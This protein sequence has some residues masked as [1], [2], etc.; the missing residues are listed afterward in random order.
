MARLEDKI[1]EIKDPELRR[2]IAEEVKE[3]KEKKQF[4]LVY[5][6]HQPEVVPVFR[7]PVQVGSTVAKKMGNLGET[8][9]VVRIH[10]GQVELIK[11]A[12][13]SREITS[14]ETLT[15]VRRMGE[16]IYPALTLIDAVENGDH[17]K[18]HHILIEAENY[19]ALQLLVYLY[20]GKVDCIYIDPP[21]NTGARDWKYNN[22]YVDRNDQWRHSKWLA[23]IGK[24]LQ[25]AKKL[26]K[27]DTGVLIITIDEHEVH[28][29][30]MLLESLFPDAYRQMVTIVV[31]PKGVT[32]GR[33][34]R[35]EEYAIFCFMKDAY[36][37]GVSDDLLTFIKN[38]GTKSKSPRWKG[39]LRSGTSARRQDRKGM[40]YPVLVDPVRGAVVGVGNPLPL[41]EEPDLEATIEGYAV[42]WPIRR[43]GSYG[44]WSVGPDTL[45]DLIAKGYVALG[46]YDEKRKTFGITYLSQEL[47]RQIQSGA[48][49][50]TGFDET[51]NCV[52][53]E[54]SEARTRAIK[55]VWHRTIH[56]AG[57][58]GSDLL[59]AI[60]GKS[61]LF[62]FPKSLYAVR[63]AIS[64]IVR[65]RPTAL[66]VDF[67][68]GSGTTLNAVNLLNLADGG[69][70]QCI[71][72]TNN[73]VSEDD[74]KRLSKQGFQ[75]GDPEWEAL[76]ICR[77][78]T[79][80]RSKYTIL[81]R[82]DD[83]T[84]LQGE[85]LTSRTVIHNKPRNIRQLSIVEGRLLTR[86]QRKELATLI[87]TV[88]QSKIT[89]APWFLDD[90]ISTSILFDVTQA[91]AWLEALMEAEHVSDFYV[92]TQE[93]RLFNTIKTGIQEL[94]GP[95]E[96]E[97]EEKH[98]LAK[99]FPVN[100]EY[101]KL[102]FLEP[103]EVAARW[104][105]ASILPILWMMSGA[106]GRCPKVHAQ[107]TPWL[108]PEDCPFVVLLHETRFREFRTK[109]EGR[110]DI[111]HVFLVTNSDSAFHDMQSELPAGII[112]VQ[113]YKNYLENFKI[114][115]QRV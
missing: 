108:I 33:F 10:D 63:D 67:F 52:T 57:A 39:L 71:L 8:Y 76:G 23:F 72:V 62:S 101:F 6:T 107:D 97:E 98:P 5:E 68:A 3:L 87:G 113:L 74:A 102:D 13:G 104:Q 88:P 95:L 99:G 18:P 12:D 111:S 37:K 59:S 100:L 35:V 61:G 91:A 70:R 53:V 110:N 4:G 31:N 94:F 14:L 73:E 78:V 105:F 109:I 106:K 25:L 49:Q 36:V 41:E 58:Y 30:G 93:S 20:A 112:A 46:K 83:G 115:I 28:H 69:S 86:G 56:D 54:Y 51:R 32:Q 90:E 81:G 9:Q 21:Y 45:R 75:T 103:S 2:A 44:R 92:V 43:D 96:I 27:P 42:A 84:P 48:I 114:N 77:S 47:Q 60:L 65:D 22:D 85:Y 29:L 66:V 64:A 38:N 1:A 26:L 15:T 16:P 80:P 55:T 17:Q 79:W 50:I 11:D 19:H 40:F 7:V 24:R 34:S 82:R 89:D